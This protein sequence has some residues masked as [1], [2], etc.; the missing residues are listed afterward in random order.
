MGSDAGYSQ[1]AAVARFRR[2]AWLAAQTESPIV[3]DLFAQALKTVSEGLL[4][5]QM[6][7]ATGAV[8]AERSA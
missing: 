6:V 2:A 8:I 4:R 5:A 7:H 3:V 1:G